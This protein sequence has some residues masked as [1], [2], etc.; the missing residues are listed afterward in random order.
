MKKF[1]FIVISAVLV[2]T[3]C[4]CSMFGNQH[5]CF[6][7]EYIDFPDG[8]DSFYFPDH[9]RCWDNIVFECLKAGTTSDTPRTHYFYKLNLSDMKFTLFSEVELLNVSNMQGHSDGSVTLTACIGEYGTRAIVDI[10]YDGKCSIREL[11]QFSKG[12]SYRSYDDY[13]KN[14]FLLEVYRYREGYI[15]ITTDGVLYMDKDAP[16]DVKIE[17]M[18]V[19]DDSF[20]GRQAGLPSYECNNDG[21]LIR[22]TSEALENK[23]SISKLNE[24]FKFEEIGEIKGASYTYNPGDKDCIY[25]SSFP[26]L[27]SKNGNSGDR[28]IYKFDFNTRKSTEYGRIM[29]GNFTGSSYLTIIDENTFLETSDEKPKLWRCKEAVETD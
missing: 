17:D 14:K 29:L 4:S 6:T 20:T 18:Y 10:G 5:R 26:F 11:P 12:I 1:M 7:P 27:N 9:K 16:D 2:L 21:T 3:M 28:I 25:Y 23:F 13:E 15:L 22:Y 19:I 24:E 8:V